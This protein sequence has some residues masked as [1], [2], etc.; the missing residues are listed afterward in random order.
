MR[1]FVFGLP[2]TKTLDPIS[3]PFTTCAFTSKVWYLCR[4]MHE[5]GHEVIHLGTEGSKP[6]CSKNIDVVSHKEWEIL[7]GKKPKEEFYNIDVD[8]PYKNYMD[9]FAANSKKALLELGGNPLESI[10]CVTWGGAQTTATQGVNQLI[11]ESGIGYPCPWADFRVYE[12]YAWMHFHLG[13]EKKF[14]GT[15]WYHCVIPNAFDPDIFGPVTQK[16]NYALYLGRL[17]DCKGTH[18][19]C[20]AARAAGL[21]IKIVGQGD[22]SPFINDVPGVEYV[23][24]VGVL[25]RREIL[26][27]AKVLICP[28]QYVEPFGGVAVEA[29]MSGTPVVSSDWGAFCET[30][31]HGYTGYRCRTFEQF[32]WAVKNIDKIDPKTCRDWAVA[33]YS[34]DKVGGMYEE[35][36]HQ[37]KNLDKKEGWALEDNSRTQLDWLRKDCSMLYS[38]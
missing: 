4:M 34:L 38:P 32:V 17:L 21:P 35:F 19:A 29:M 31:Q 15:K 1:I 23:P 5:R 25:E 6:I 12:S 8:G 27:K 20:R 33:N 18:I 11:V 3:S 7:Y 2:H 36:F 22:P 13:H 10:V 37:L 9:K 28:T 30:V 26:R 16:E 24:P 14:D